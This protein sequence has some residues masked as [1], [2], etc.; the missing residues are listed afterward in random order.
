MSTIS[1]DDV[2]D[3]VSQP[4]ISGDI[5]SDILRNRLKEMGAREILEEGQIQ[6]YGFPFKYHHPLDEAI[7]VL[8]YF[9]TKNNLRKDSIVHIHSIHVPTK[10]EDNTLAFWKSPKAGVYLDL[11]SLIENN[12]RKRLGNNSSERSSGLIQRIF[13]FRDNAHLAFLESTGIGVILEQQSI[14]IKT[15]FILRDKQERDIREMIEGGIILIQLLPK[16]NKP[17]DWAEW[18]LFLD[19]ANKTNQPYRNQ[20]VCKWHKGTILDADTSEKENISLDRYLQLFTDLEGGPAA[21]KTGGGS[22]YFEG[23]PSGFSELLRKN[24]DMAFKEKVPNGYFDKLK[25]NYNDLLDIKA[26]PSTLKQLHAALDRIGESKQICAV[27]S[28][29]VK[30]TLRV[31]DTDPNYRHWIRQTINLAI[32]DTKVSLER[33]YILDSGNQAKG[34]DK[35]FEQEVNLYRDFLM[36][37][38]S[39]L[40]DVWIPQGTSVENESAVADFR[41]NPDNIKLYVIT[42]RKINTYCEN[43][44]EKAK[45]EQLTELSTYFFKNSDGLE[46][47]DEAKR[48]LRPEKKLQ[49]LSFFLSHLDFLY[50]EELL[51]NYEGYKGEPGQGLYDADLFVPSDS[52]HDILPVDTLNNRETENVITFLEDAEFKS[53]QTVYFR[54]FELLKSLSWQVLPIAGDDSNFDERGYLFP[55]LSVLD[56]KLDAKRRDHFIK[57]SQPP[58]ETSKMETAYVCFMDIADFTDLEIDKQ[59]DI[60]QRLIE[61]VR[62]TDEFGRSEAQ[63]FIRAPAGDG[64]ALVF[65]EDAASALR[66]AIEV[67]R[68]LHKYPELPLR[69]GIH[70]GLVTRSTD[71]NGTPNVIGDGINFA[72]R[73]MSCGDAGHILASKAVADTLGR[74]KIWAGS[75]HDLGLVR[76]KKDVPIHIYNVYAND[77]GNHEPPKKVL[78]SKNVEA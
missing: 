25:A 74:V 70:T 38:I 21:L 51:F 29:S 45:T 41:A 17:C 24:F 3:Y 56:E 12:N 1:F 54:F 6:S 60:V 26:T 49:W 67:N 69:M 47:T 14:G 42:K 30:S 7:L 9:L 36:N 59:N 27:D 76:V 16:D 20:L 50:S 33:I 58:A 10:E 2:V 64:M 71:I 15:G 31:H 40:D 34:D 18:A 32:H 77:Y 46:L 19:K 55:P 68:E 13:V 39:R 28:S 4:E 22:Y 52:A 23:E 35:I 11:H 5:P 37:R 43:L 63:E 78:E 57:L 61:V 48:K 8:H 53:K 44:S 72:Q 65:F 75:F 73:V 66:C 62:S